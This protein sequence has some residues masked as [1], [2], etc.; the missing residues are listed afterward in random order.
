LATRTAF[1]DALAFWRGGRALAAE[2]ACASIL[3]VPG[4]HAD[5]CALLADIYSATGRSAGAIDLLRRVSVLRPQ[6]AAARRRLGDALFAS[7]AWAEAA[8]SFRQ[9]IA[10]EPGNARAYNNLGRAQAKLGERDAATESYRRAIELEPNYAIAHNN[11]GTVL[12]ETHQHEEALAC[13]RRAAMLNARFTEAHRNAGNVLMRLGRAAEALQSHER[14]LELEPHNAAFQRNCADALLCLQEA[15]A[16][17]AR[18]DAALR[19]DPKLAAAYNGRGTALRLLRRFDDALRS[20][21]SAIAIEPELVEAHANKA[22]L[23]MEMERV[24]EA[25]EWCDQMLAQWPDF[26]GAL[27][28]RALSLGFLPQPRYSDAATDFAK[29]LIVEPAQHYTLGYLLHTSAMTYDWSRDTLLNDGLAGLAASRPVIM[30]LALLALTD[31]AETQLQCARVCVSNSYPPAPRPVW[32]GERRQHSKIRIAYISGDLREHALSFLSVGM[33]EQH[34]RERFEVYGISLRPPVGSAFGS[35]VLSAFDA[36]LDV[37]QRS[38]LDI[39][40]FLH[41]LEIDIAVDLMGFTRGHRINIFAHRGAPV[42]VSYLGYPGTTGAPYMD[43][44]IADEYLLPREH[45][46]Q[47][48][49]SVVYLPHCFQAN[50][51]RRV[52]ADTP[53]SRSE[54]GLP[55]EAFVFCSFNNSYQVTEAMFGIWC[56]LLLAR[57]DSVLWILA[58]SDAAKANLVHAASSLGVDPGRLVFAGQLPYAQHLARLRL[59]DLMLDS[60]PFNGGTTASDALWAGLPLVTCSG[61]AFA[62]RMAGSLLQALGLPELITDS[63]TAYEILALQLASDPARLAALRA[64]LQ[65]NRATHPPFRTRDFCRQL[66]R[67]YV[68]MHGRSQRGE[69]AADITINCAVAAGP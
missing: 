41:E 58:D 61:E 66:E 29:L 54:V 40:K 4:D 52:I 43:Y 2:V 17:L 68:E 16:A 31:R 63:L 36:F 5:A 53:T 14:A 34:D 47:V 6:D 18:Y 46:S 9:A 64:R 19:A 45:R 10:L 25:I 28:Y 30:P 44:V 51:D 57:P 8:E 7:G 24:E 60:F 22:S 39:A 62:S 13:Y 21:E 55:E 26:P 59:A 49:E 50:D 23:L 1:A 33:F 3:A 35:R 12:G 69:P 38:D 11:L 65:E 15:P 42:Q 56:R 37:H 48:S 20:Y 27:L 32:T 67:A